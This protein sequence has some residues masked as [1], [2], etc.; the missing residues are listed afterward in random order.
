[1]TSKE[2]L[3]TV[4]NKLLQAELDSEERLGFN[5]AFKVISVVEDMVDNEPIPAKK[6]L[7]VEDG[8]VDVGGL[9]EC[10]PPDIKVIVYRQGST[11]P[12]L[13]EV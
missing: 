5:E 11:M 6:L 1:M 12:V 7:F 2:I 4:K 10:L 9:A 3:L 8:S 13:K